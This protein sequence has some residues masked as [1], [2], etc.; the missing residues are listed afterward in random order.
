MANDLAYLGGG[1]LSGI[2]KGLVADAAGKA[3]R[4]AARADLEAELARDVRKRDWSR[5]DAD[6]KHQRTQGEVTRT[7]TDAEG[8]TFGITR[9]GEKV[10]LKIKGMPGGG[11]TGQDPARVKEANWLVKNGIYP[12]LATAYEATRERVGMNDEDK[13]KAAITWAADQKN[14]FGE[15]LYDTPEKLAGAVSSYQKL[16]E[17]DSE[18]FVRSLKKVNPDEAP[19]PEQQAKGFFE[20]L[21]SNDESAVAATPAPGRDLPG[22]ADTAGGA[23]AQP[24][25]DGTEASPFRPSTQEQFDALPTGA[26]FINPKDGKPYRKK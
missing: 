15:P 3:A 19:K 10:D 25:G 21:F 8:N 20:S 1:L 26:I 16:L 2:G 13:R 11:K 17:G 5:E 14:E 24:Q 12:D 23:G 9:G 22:P 4:E 6:L 7:E 18:G